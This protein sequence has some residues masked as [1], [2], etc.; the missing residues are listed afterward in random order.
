MIDVCLH[1]C[2][3]SHT[4]G[5][6]M[7]GANRKTEVEKLSKGVNLLIGTPGKNTEVYVRKVPPINSIRV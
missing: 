3:F 7:G 1:K 5:I 6:V 4:F 2:N